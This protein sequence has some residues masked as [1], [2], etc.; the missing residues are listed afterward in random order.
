MAFGQNT[1]PSLRIESI[2]RYLDTC[3]CTLL[4][5]GGSFKAPDTTRVGRVIG[6]IYGVCRT[7]KLVDKVFV[8]REI[9][10]NFVRPLI[11]QPQDLVHLMRYGY[12]NSYGGKGI[13]VPPSST[14]SYMYP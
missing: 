11:C 6:K 12:L 3:L 10:R 2:F 14:K 9:A 7:W 5:H 8:S 1:L 13:D 4:T